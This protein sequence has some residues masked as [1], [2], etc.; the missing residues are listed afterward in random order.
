MTCSVC[1]QEIRPTRNGGYGHVTN[2]TYRH[3]YARPLMEGR[4]RSASP[5]RKE[6][7]ARD[8]S[9]SSRPSMSSRTARRG[10]SPE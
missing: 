6:S 2:P 9:A 8:R 5:R 10:G 4:D 1:L 3:H 7:E